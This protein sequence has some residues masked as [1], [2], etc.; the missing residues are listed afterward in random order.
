MPEGIKLLS[1][2]AHKD[3]A[4]KVAKH[5][6][7]DLTDTTLT[8]FSDGEILVKINENV[9]GYDVLLSSRPAPR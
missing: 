7:M 4:K 8:T 9:R 2:N 5:L 6:K 1:G 3:L